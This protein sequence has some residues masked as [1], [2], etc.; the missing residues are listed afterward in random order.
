[1]ENVPNCH[2]SNNIKEWHKWTKTLEQL[3]YKNFWKDL[4]SKDYEVPQTRN[5]CYMVSILDCGDKVYNFPKKKKLKL[6][7]K[8]LLESN[9][10]EKYYLSEQMIKGMA[11][12]KFQSYSLL[13]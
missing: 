1:M 2:G 3:G 4:N 8:D 11:S 12:T 6:L 7:L 10:D 5:R 9:V 13:L